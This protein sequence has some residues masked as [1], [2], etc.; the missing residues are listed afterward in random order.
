VTEPDERDE[1]FDP[2]VDEAVRQMVA[3]E[4]APGFAR[5]VMARVEASAPR[6]KFAFPWRVAAMGAAAAAVAL[7]M[8]L[9]RRP[10]SPVVQPAPA[11][12]SNP[13]IPAGPPPV[14]EPAALATGPRLAAAA[15]PEPVPLVEL[16]PITIVP[17]GLEPIELLDSGVALVDVAPL[18][19][20]HLEISPLE[21]HQ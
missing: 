9:S 2:H 7:V 3:G 15:T 4:P 21:E 17:I 18:I 11:V 10:A 12:A 16:N 14:T 5:L 1:R 8:L 19:V 6:A 20:E 13:S